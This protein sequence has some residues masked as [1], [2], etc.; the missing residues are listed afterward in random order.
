MS[1]D[2]HR[3]TATARRRAASLSRIVAITL[4][5]ALPGVAVASVA[6]TAGAAVTAARV[7][8]V[9]GRAAAAPTSPQGW[10]TI[11]SS[12]VPGVNNFF[13]GSTCADAW[14]CWNVGGTISNSKN[15]PIAGVIHRYNGTAWSAVKTQAPAGRG[16]VFIDVT[17]VS[18][19]DCWAVGAAQGTNGPPSPLTEHWNGSS[20]SISL[21]AA[22]HGYLLGVSCAGPDECFA[23]GAR[24]DSSA[25]QTV[26]LSYRWN[27]SSWSIEPTIATGQKY[28]ELSG[29]ACQSESSC[30]A[31]GTDGLNPQNSNFLPVVPAAAGDQSL[32]ARWNGS[33][34]SEVASPTFSDGGYLSAVTCSGPTCWAV[35]SITTVAGGAETALIERSDG[36]G[37]TQVQSPV[38]SGPGKDFLHQVTCVNP[39]YCVAVGAD[40]LGP[41]PHA[42]GSGP[43][44]PIAAIWNGSSWSSMATAPVAGNFAFLAGVA[45][46]GGAKCFAAGL[47]GVSHNQGLIQNLLEQLI[48]PPGY[49]LAATDGGVFSFGSAE[50]HGVPHQGGIVAVASPGGGGYWLVSSQG[51]VFGFGDAAYHGRPTGKLAGPIVGIAPTSDGNGYWLVGA[52]GGVFSFGDAA[53][54]GSMG[55]RHLSSPV[56][57]I[58]ATADGGGYWLVG[59]DGGVFSFGDAAYHGSMG[60]RH[61]G[62]PVVGMA[63][64]PDGGGYWLVGS[65]GGVFSFGDAAYH[66]SMGGKHLGAP[67]VGMAAAPDGGGYWLVGADGGVFSFG[68]ATFGGSMGGKVLSAP[69]TGIA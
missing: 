16:W 21:D 47:Y 58:I 50:F 32:V 14:E 52:D 6:S 1:I 13:V 51:A 4:V 53:Y 46:A 18:N 40:G 9:I 66:G 29:V 34:W 5:V 63:A 43:V 27:G 33:A 59:S 36:T 49:W 20:W 26:D 42:F 62:A 56:V 23:V 64:A 54:H 15:S 35:G 10:T 17:C 24:T 38:F 30:W 48:L 39:A 2:D 11:A 28:S 25:D 3:T 22:I 37:W 67:V 45:C 65:D 60:G 55:G 7:T 69:V 31:V 68:D 8:N 12:D 41:P 44:Q 19:D 61:L 57:G